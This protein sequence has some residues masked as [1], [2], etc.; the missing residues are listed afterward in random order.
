[1]PVAPRNKRPRQ[2]RQL[3]GMRR[4]KLCLLSVLLA[5]SPLASALEIEPFAG[6]GVLFTDNAKL[7]ENNEDSDQILTGLVGAKITGNDGPFR[8]NAD[9]S[10]TYE[11]YLNNTY[12]D[13]HWFYLNSTAGWEMI[14]DRVDWGVR[15]Y[16][17]QTQV[18]NLNSD[19][20][21]N[22]QNT[23]VF[24]FGPNI[25][26][27][28]SARQVITVRPL[29][30][31][32]YYQDSDTD[33]Q[34]YGVSADWLYKLRPDMQAGINGGATTVR[35]KKDDKNPDY[36]AYNLRGVV[37]GTRPRSTYRIEMG[38]TNISRDNAEDQNGFSAKLDWLY[39]ITGHSSVRAY[40]ATDLTDSSQ[41]L[42][43][44][45]IDPG[46]GDYSN[47]QTSGDV[48]R[49]KIFRMSYLR[50]DSTLNSSIW[51]EFRD[52]DYKESPDDR[53]IKEIGAKLD[54]Q[55]TAVV[56]TGI[57]G[58]YNKT[59]ETDINRDDKRYET[60]VTA[61]YSLSRKLSTRLNLQYRK[62]DSSSNNDGYT[63]YSA[64]LGLV[65]GLGSIPTPGG[66]GY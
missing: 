34:Q 55:V 22:L 35:Y 52:L 23:N 14:R 2:D 15:D 62:K 51:T 43:N 65:Y 54:Y 12:G 17:T 45:Q 53:E 38:R 6:A 32:F 47:V 39:N 16:F 8:A 57:Y 60:G 63:E 58:R 30:T 41:Q 24:S 27:P 28:L 10:L 26:L 61:S 4:L 19:T 20:P 5:L 13:K 7:T 33:N 1:M 31:D 21:S 44:S 37:T 64:F 25:T 11:N 46:T 18:N 49:N 56:S 40:A 29:F 59:K 36:S 48:L 9:T 3:N 42:L 50:K 66:Y